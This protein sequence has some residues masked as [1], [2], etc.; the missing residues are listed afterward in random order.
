M[1]SSIPCSFKEAL[2]LHD[3][4]PGPNGEGSA[5]TPK[6][7]PLT[8]F[9]IL[10]LGMQP[11][12]R[13]FFYQVPSL[14][15]T[16]LFLDSIVPKL[17]HSLFLTLHHYLPLAGNLTWPQD[18]H[19][20]MVDSAVTGATSS[21]KKLVYTV[22]CRPRLKLAIPSTCFGNCVGGGLEFVEADDLVGEDGLV[23]AVVVLSKSIR[24]MDCM[25]GFMWSKEDVAGYIHSTA[26]TGNEMGPI[27][28]AGSPRFEVYSTDF[29]WGR[30]KK[31]EMTFIDRTGAICM[32]ES[33]N[34]N[35]GVEIGLALKLKKMEA[36]ASFFAK[37]LEAL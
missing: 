13:L 34:G 23:S 11:L 18:S 24:N 36:F 9:H 6:S 21:R 3:T 4:A 35:G 30:P 12:Q 1:H 27:G 25:N 19:K 29:G 14:I 16:K 8:F 5:A 17:K 33:K 22:D 15:T 32:S 28:V 7:L 26:E 37:G 2:D 31:V 10:F 20:P